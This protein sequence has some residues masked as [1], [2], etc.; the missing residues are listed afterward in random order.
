MPASM[1]PAAISV[2]WRATAISPLASRSS[3][4]VPS[5]SASRWSDGPKLTRP[6]L[7]RPSPTSVG[8]RPKPMMSK[9]SSGDGRCERSANSSIRILSSRRWIDVSTIGR[10]SVMKPGL[11]PVLWIDVPPAWRRPPRSARASWGPCSP[12]GGTRRASSP[13]CCPPPAGGRPRRSRRRAACRGRSPG[14]SARTSSIEPVA[15]TPVG[16]SPASSPAS[17]PTLSGSYTWTPTSSRSG[18]SSTPC[19]DRVPM[20]P[21]AHWTTRSRAISRDAPNPEG[22]RAQASSRSGWV[23]VIQS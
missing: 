15:S 10:A 20:L 21:V 18:C 13:R 19:S 17:R 9:S 12:A 16:A 4:G 11:L 22:A 23:V 8:S 7:S 6:W 3:R 5:A 1:V 14:C 2:V